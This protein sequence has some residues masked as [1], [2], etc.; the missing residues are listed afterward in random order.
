MFIA[1]YVDDLLLFSADIDSCID[2]I[3]QNLWNRFWKTDL[4]DISHYLRIEE[5]V[6]HS[7]KTIIFWQSTYLKKMLE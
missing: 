4:S 6:D 7:K 2:D 1:I 3:M 5:D